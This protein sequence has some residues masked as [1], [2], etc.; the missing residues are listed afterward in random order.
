MQARFSLKGD[1]IPADADLPT[2]LGLHHH[3]EEAEVGVMKQKGKSTPISIFCVYFVRFLLCQ[4]VL[5][6][7]TSRKCR[8]VV[9]FGNKLLKRSL[10]AMH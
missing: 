2:H 5:V 8:W 10:V 3:G 4:G 7:K 6:T 1:L 9:S